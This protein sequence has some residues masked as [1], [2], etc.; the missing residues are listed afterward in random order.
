MKDSAFIAL[1]GKVRK[2]ELTP[3]HRQTLM[4]YLIDFH[5]P[6]FFQALQVGELSLLNGSRSCI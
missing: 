4:T 2:P 5:G 6:D 3:S 1:K